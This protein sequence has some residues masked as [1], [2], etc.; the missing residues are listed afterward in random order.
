MQWKLAVTFVC[1]VT[2]LCSLYKLW[3][4]FF[5]DHVYAIACDFVMNRQLEQRTNVKF[6]IQHCYRDI[7]YASASL[8]WQG[9]GSYSMFW[10]AQ[11]VQKQKNILGRCRTILKTCRECQHHPEM[12]GEINQLLHDDHRRTINNI[13]DVF[14]LLLGSCRRS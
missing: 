10:V 11:A 3:N 13:A 5:C 7:G 4:L 6:W 2:S 14:G 8:Q 9:N 1:Q 12:W